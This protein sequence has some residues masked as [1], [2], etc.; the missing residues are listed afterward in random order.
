MSEKT[1]FNRRDF[2]KIVGATT[3]MAATGCAQDVPEKLIPYVV[4]PDEVIPGVASWYA[5]TCGECSAGCGTLVRTRE[6]RAVK[7][8]GNRAHPVNRGGLCSM[9]QSSLQQLY[10]PDRVREPLKRKVNE[11]FKPVTWESALADVAKAIKASDAAGK[12]TVFITGHVGGSAKVL[13]DSLVG[14]LKNGVQLR[15]EL[16]E[17]EVLTAAA[18]RVF[19]QDVRPHYHFDKADVVVGFGADYLETFDS[20]VE[21]TKDFSKRRVPDS[22]G[23][24]SEVFHF[25]PRLS[26]T[27]TNAD[28]FYKIA[29]ESE[30]RILRVLLAKTLTKAPAPKG[31]RAAAER[32]IVGLNV[33]SSLKGTGVSEKQLDALAAKLIEH[34][35]SSLII[36]GGASLRGDSGGDAA[37]YALLLNAVLGAIGTTVSL[38]AAESDLQTLSSFLHERKDS[39]NDDIGVVFVSGTNPAYSLPTTSSF[40]KLATSAGLLVSLTTNIDE[41]SSLANIVLPASTGFEAWSDGESAP[42]VYTINQPSMQPLYESQGLGDTLIALA[43]SETLDLKLSEATSF[44]DFIKEQWSKR[45]GASG[46]EDRW[47]K[48]VQNGGDWTSAVAAGVA[49]T[50]SASLA[51]S[52]TATEKEESGDKLRLLAFPTVRFGDGAAANRPW[53]QEIPDP[54]TT[55]VWGSWIEVNPV[56]LAKLGMKHGDVLQVHTDRGAFEAPAY[57]SKYVHEDVI[58]VPIGMGHESMGRY[59][60]GVGVNPLSVMPIAADGTV[61]FLSTVSK[62]S[63]S[64]VE[65]EL[66]TLQGNDSQLKRGIYRSVGLAEL[67]KSANGHAHDEHGADKHGSEGHGAD[68]HADDAHGEEGHGGGHH[69]P[70][71]LGPRDEP[72]QMYKQMEHVQYRW[73]MSVDLASCTGCSAC[74]TAC[75]AEN[76]VPVVGKEFCAQGRE[77]SWIRLERYFDG[78]ET[79]PVEGFVPVMCQHCGNAPCEPVCPVYATYHSDEGLNTMVYNRCVGTRYCGNNCSYKVRRFNW[80][81]YA[82]PEPLNWQLNPDVTVRTTGVME[83]CTF[84]IQRIREGENT[85]KNEGREVADGEIQPACASSCPADAIKFGNLKDT[86]SEVY[87]NSQSARGYKVLDFELNTQPA[88]TY[89]AEVVHDDLPKK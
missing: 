14:K 71:A 81:D 31:S 47:L 29:P 36:A 79:K 19:G 22:H 40:T 58:A 30:A 12:K 87:A 65:E 42:G 64:I 76:N 61:S 20:P 86:H 10:D 53:L 26:L 44:E 18:K 33:A 55:A 74:V 59:A 34:A 5:A 50:I 38:R 77:M 25:E 78:P 89:L 83:K 11:P 63:K 9:A 67:Q 39:K 75:Y 54:M 24:I 66:I 16:F 80:F 51:S 49:W 17:S 84:C 57:E 70:L 2:L 7:V 56:R 88:V 21:Y 3:G 62:L 35:S 73:G 85:A 28:T 32:A 52:F 68:S 69:D 23:K 8:E 37:A 6:G 46:F 27:A 82:W 4:Q 43:A 15:H 60:D 48:Y 41:T 72:K 45:T 1:G 13:L